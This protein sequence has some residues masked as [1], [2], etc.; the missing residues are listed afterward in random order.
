MR[1]VLAVLGILVLL[2][3]MPAGA[4][5]RPPVREVNHIQDAG[6]GGL[7]TPL[8]A[9]DFYGFVDAQFGSDAWLDLWAGEPFESDV[10]LTR[11]SDAP[12]SVTF[13]GDTVSMSIP[14]VS[15]GVD[16]SLA[17]G[18]AQVDGT[19]TPV[20]TISFSDRFREGNQWFR[21]TTEGLFYT[22]TGT[23]TL[24]G[25]DPIALDPAFCTGIDADQTSFVTQPN[26]TV[27]SFS[28]AG[29]LCEVGNTDGDTAALFFFP[30]PDVIFV[31][32]EVTDASG[33]TIGISGAGELDSEGTTTFTLSEFDL[34]TFEPLPTSG[35]ASVSVIDAGE[36]FSYT[37]RTSNGYERV[38]GSILD[39]EGSVST[40]LGSF[41]LDA[42]IA[43]QSD[44]K[45]VT[46]PSSGPKPGGKRP[47]NDLPSGAIT[48]RPGFKATVATRGAQQPAEGE[49]PCLTF[50][51]PFDGTVYTSEAE[52]TVWYR[53]AGTGGQVTVDTAGSDFDTVLAVYAGS[54]D[55]TVIG[56]VDDTP[57]EPVGR[58]LQGQVELRDDRRHHLLGAD[59]RAQR[60]AGVRT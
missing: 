45:Q 19:L 16:P 23:I 60:G 59:R 43:T 38:R 26:A 3:G 2:A 6:C 40:S 42:C 57:L 32:G 52:H 12:A 54:P 46:T 20:D 7:A 35:T 27:Q 5:A 18:V 4:V 58:T 50:T 49:Y 28:S 15:T 55:G 37:L 29:G 1:R 34:E 39:I 17:S 8:G 14:V 51:D 53:I 56:C 13:S 31:D 47:A 24:P 44:V 41:D 11:D 48:V 25:E 9:L 10:L 33:S 36:V 22:V 30:Q 21:F